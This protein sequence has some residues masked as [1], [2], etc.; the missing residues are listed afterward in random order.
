MQ[1]PNANQRRAAKMGADTDTDK[2]FLVYFK[3]REFEALPKEKVMRWGAHKASR[4]DLQG[5]PQL[6][7]AV[8]LAQQAIST[9]TQ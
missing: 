2:V 8:H 6:S 9:R 1:E 7:D 4:Q 3:T 5:Y